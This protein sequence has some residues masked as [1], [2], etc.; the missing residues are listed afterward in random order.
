MRK[1]IIG[2]PL[3]GVDELCHAIQERGTEVIK[4]YLEE[5]PENAV[6]GG[7]E[8]GD[9]WKRL[10]QKFPNDMFIVVTD[11]VDD[12]SIR[13]A[14]WT[15]QLEVIKNQGH[16]SP[17]ALIKPLL[18]DLTQD[19]G[20]LAA[21]FASFPNRV[22]KY[23]VANGVDIKIADISS[24]K[25]LDILFTEFDI[26]TEKPAKGGGSFTQRVVRFWQERRTWARAG[27]PL[28]TAERM[29]ELYDEKCS[30]CEF[31]K[32]SACDLCGCNIRR[33]GN[34]LNK[35]AWATTECPDGR[36]KK[37]VEPENI[38]SAKVG[39]SRASSSCCGK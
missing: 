20:I 26:A 33:E 5:Y 15:A 6:V 34:A 35:L 32:N 13:I 17:M 4:E 8:L 37:E 39:K 30:P 27:K 23:G 10:I 31:Y 12:W 11:N 38:S 22:F 36:W 25:G 3:S 7:S 28:R 29:A 16:L 2:M 14:S 21:L 19:G 18:G 24:S 1:F 9:D